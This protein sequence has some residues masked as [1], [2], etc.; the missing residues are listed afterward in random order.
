MVQ[1][2]KENGKI[3]K[4]MEKE[5]FSMLIEMYLKENG[6]MIKQMDMEYIYIVM[7]LN[8]Q[9]LKKYNLI[10]TNISVMLYYIILKLIIFNVGYWKDDL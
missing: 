7:E 3:I 2:M 6:L 4:L 5:N 9:V 1:D 8:I 10:N